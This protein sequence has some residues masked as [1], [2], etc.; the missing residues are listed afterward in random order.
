MIL[1]SKV[2]LLTAGSCTHHNNID[3]GGTSE[4]FDRTIDGLGACAKVAERVALFSYSSWNVHFNVTA[5]GTR[6][7]SLFAVC[8]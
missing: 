5:L 6:A 7:M 3:D 8:H 2:L 4:P 1:H